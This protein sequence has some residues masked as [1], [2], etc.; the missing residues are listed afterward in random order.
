LVERTSEIVKRVFV[1]SGEYP[2]EEECILKIHKVLS[3]RPPSGGAHAIL[4]GS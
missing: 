2:K 3:T 1:L 4:K